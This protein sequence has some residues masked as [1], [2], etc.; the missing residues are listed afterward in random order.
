MGYGVR[1]ECAPEEVR[2]IM[3]PAH[4][5]PPIKCLD[6]VSGC[7]PTTIRRVHHQP[8]GTERPRLAALGQTLPIANVRGTSALP[9]IA[10][11]LVRRGERRKG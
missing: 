5:C 6:N 4:C 8:N 11:E 3:V 2:Q 10:T 7:R 9:P 1:K